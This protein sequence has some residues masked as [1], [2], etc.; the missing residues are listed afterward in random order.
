MQYSFE[1][2]IV[3][4]K[5]NVKKELQFYRLQFLEK[6]NC[7]GVIIKQEII[8][9][10]HLT[11]TKIEN[12]GF[13]YHIEVFDTTL[14]NRTLSLSEKD[15]IAQI[16]SITDDVKIIVDENFNFIKIKNFDLIK[17][18]ANQKFK[19]LSK[20]YLGEKANRLFE[21]LQKY[22]K[23]EKLIYNDLQRYD[24]YGFLL[25]KFL[26]YYR[27]GKNH[28]YTIRY[29]NFLKNTFLEIDETVKMT[30]LNREIEEV[31]LKLKGEINT[32][33]YNKK[34]FEREM[35][36]QNIFFDEVNDNLTLNKYEGV[37]NFNTKTGK[38]NNAKLNIHVSFGE[39]YSKEIDY[40]L[41]SLLPHEV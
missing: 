3:E 23:D 28:K 19:I 14:R 27:F 1:D 21:Y 34:M 7:N 26:G 20:K 2:N 8:K 4:V 11:I 31:E 5:P 35:K 16:A 25:I 13:E 24:K 10:V 17:S 22:Y 30:K 33:K 36:V 38:I 12:V 37:F 41:S 15:L 9:N 6:M 32:S 18:K 29:T 39:N 40:Q